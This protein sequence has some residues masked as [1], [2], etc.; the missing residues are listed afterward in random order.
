MTNAS[1]GFCVWSYLCP[2]FDVCRCSSLPLGGGLTIITT[3]SEV[4]CVCVCVCVC[5]VLSSALYVD[6]CCCSS[7]SLGRD[8][9]MVTP[10]AQILFCLVALFFFFFFYLFI[11]LIFYVFSCYSLSLAGG[12]TCF[13]NCI[14]FSLPLGRAHTI[15]TACV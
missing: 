11:Y 4:V 13:D 9:T 8:Q 1:E 14:C 5:V 12:L 3:A 10:H 6:V 15:V 7:L 2:M